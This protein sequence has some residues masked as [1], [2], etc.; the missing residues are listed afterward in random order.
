[1]GYILP[2]VYRKLLEEG[3]TNQKLPNIF[4]ETGTFK[5]GIPHR[6]LENRVNSKEDEIL[7]PAFNKY[8]TIELGKSLCQIASTRYGLFEV[9]GHNTSPH[10]IH[11]DEKDPHFEGEESFFDDRLTLIQGD[12]ATVMK[13]LMSE[14]FQPVCFWLDAH[15]GAAKYAKGEDDVPLF[16]ELEVIKNHGIKNHIISIDDAHMFGKVQTNNQGL[17]TCDYSNITFERIREKIQAINPK[18]DVNIY[19]PYGM[20]MVLAYVKQ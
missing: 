5:G 1:M 3:Q 18:Y 11:T 4:I 17:I 2:E 7:D 16:R 13:Q 8:Y 10:M 6:I 19:Q 15:A 9:H 14:I 12:S 20:P